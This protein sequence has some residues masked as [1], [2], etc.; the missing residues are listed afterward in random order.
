MKETTRSRR[1]ESR[2]RNEREL[3]ERFLLSPEEIETAMKE[4]GGVEPYTIAKMYEDVEHHEEW[5]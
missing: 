1:T 5:R 4:Y 2:T 3:I